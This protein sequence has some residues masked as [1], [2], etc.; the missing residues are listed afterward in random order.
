M[1]PEEHFDQIIDAIARTHEAVVAGKLFGVR[2][3]KANGKAFAA[4]HRGAMVFKLDGAPHAEALALPGAALWD[5]SDEGRAMRAW[6]AVP[7]AHGARWE[8]LAEAAVA[9]MAGNR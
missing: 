9:G 8:A 1:P 4:F 3:I 7:A 5:P 2:C 6:V